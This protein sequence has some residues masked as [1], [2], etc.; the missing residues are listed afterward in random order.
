MNNSMYDLIKT[1]EAPM[2]RLIETVYKKR[3]YKPIM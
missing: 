2:R 1:S 3:Q